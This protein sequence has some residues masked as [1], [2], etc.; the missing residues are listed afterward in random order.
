[1]ILD[2]TLTCSMFNEHIKGVRVNISSTDFYTW[3]DMKISYS[4][5][6]CLANVAILDDITAC[7]DNLSN[8]ELSNV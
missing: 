6:L 7:E 8:C 2:D 4:I 1:M 3:I 5:Y